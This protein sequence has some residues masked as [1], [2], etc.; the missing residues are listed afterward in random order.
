M[1]IIKELTI[2]D[3]HISIFKMEQK[4]T[5]KLEW[6]RLEQVFKLDGREGME[7][8]DRILAV[9]DKGFIQKVKGTFE[10]MMD[11][12]NERLKALQEM[13]DEEFPEII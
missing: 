12:K 11:N 13:D 8:L 3:I 6:K 1:R 5:M 4:F 2:E 7:D 10:F 9:I